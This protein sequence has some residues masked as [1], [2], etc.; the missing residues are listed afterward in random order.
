MERLGYCNNFKRKFLFDFMTVNH[1]Y[2][3]YDF[4]ISSTVLGTLKD[5]N[6]MAPFFGEA[7]T[8]PGR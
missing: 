1:R 8:L 7:S 4:F 5:V 6:D 3:C 2:S